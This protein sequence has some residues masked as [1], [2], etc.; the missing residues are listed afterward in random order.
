MTEKP[1]GAWGF[2]PPW[3]EKDVREAAWTIVTNRKTLRDDHG[4]AVD[5]ASAYVD[6]P[7]VGYGIIRTLSADEMQAVESWTR[8][9]MA[10]N[11]KHPERG[12]K[13]A[14]PRGETEYDVKLRGFAAELAVALEAGLRWNRA[15]LGRRYRHGEKVADVGKNVEVR[16]ALRQDGELAIYDNDPDQRICVLVTGRVPTFTIRGWIRAI[17][18]RIGS[19]QPLGN[20]LRWFIPME[21][22]ERLPLPGDA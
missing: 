20:G 18:G 2:G 5:W 14:P 16:N 4:V 22:L 15:L 8:E 1:P 17:D 21:Q 7:V 11:A 13:Y 19:G 9:V 10:D 12:M 3:T 6:S